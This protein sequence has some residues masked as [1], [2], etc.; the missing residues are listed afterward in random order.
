METCLMITIP[1]VANLR[2][3]GLR[4]LRMAMSVAQHKIVNVLKKL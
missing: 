3:M 2:P 1:G 4:W